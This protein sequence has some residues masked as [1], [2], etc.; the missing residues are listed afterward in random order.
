MPPAVQRHALPAAGFLA[1][2][3]RHI[4]AARLRAAGAEPAALARCTV[5]LPS[6]AAAG[7]FAAAWRAASASPAVI[8]PRLTTLQAWASGVPLGRG[9][10][11]A[12]SREAQLYEALAHRRWFGQADRWAVAAE[13][14]ALFDALTRARVRLPASLQ[15]FTQYI[16]AAYGAGAGTQVARLGEPLS[17][18]AR[19]VHDLWRAYGEAGEAGGPLDPETAYALRLSIL[20]EHAGEPLYVLGADEGRLSPAEAD[21]LERYAL[22]AEVTLFSVDTAAGDPL[23]RA[24]R[25]AWPAA[26]DEHLPA[27]ALRLRETVK[28]SPLAGRVR[29]AALPG[30]EAEARAIDFQVRAWLQA[31]H[32]SIAVVV[33]DRVVARRARALLERAQVLVEDE[34]GWALSTTSAATAVGRL[35]DVVTGDGYHRE[36]LDLMKSPFVFQDVPRAARRTAV[37]RFE[38]LL[39][40]AGPAGGVNDLLAL[41]GRD[42]D[43][44][45]RAMLERVASACRAFSRKRD[46]LA[47]WLA[48]LRAALSA[49]GIDRGFAGDA[50]GAQVLETLDALAS[51]LQGETLA[52]SLT[53]WRRWLMRRVESATFRDRAIASPVT[54][55][56]LAGTRLRRYDA[57][58]IAGADAAHLPG[59]APHARFF[60]QGVRR[61]LGLPLHEQTLREMRADLASLIAGAGETLI[62]WRGAAE[63]EP[64]LLSP[65]IE[66]LNTLHECAWGTRLEDAALDR[67][68]RASQVEAERR[69]PSLPLPALSAR[70]APGAPLP[71]L[72]AALT[73]SAY[74]DLVDCP[75]RFHVRHMLGLKE[76]DEVSEALEK[77]DY[78]SHV[79][80]VLHE[81]HLAHPVVSALAPEAA[82]Q[83]LERI[84]ERVFRDALGANY[85]D[86]AWLARWKKLIPAYIE[87]QS[88][89]EDGGWRY[90]QGELQRE[91]TLATPG[92]RSIV[93]R[94]RLD[95]VD[96]HAG[97]GG[98]DDAYALVDY[99]TRAP[100][101]LKR[102]LAAPGEDVQL[103]V[104]ALLWGA[105]VEE[106]FY[107]SL[108]GDDI[109]AVPASPEADAVAQR[110]VRLLDDLHAGAALPAHGD[111]AVCAH[112]E[113]YGLCRRPYWK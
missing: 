59:P 101:R 25:A 22:R 47:G 12:A 88:A 15:D 30:L 95:R 113:A 29:I 43:A 77:S 41:A 62:T 78:G 45:T 37:A 18:E 111:E 3:A 85:L 55:V 57:V 94:G 83:A 23:D 106:A 107:L 7:D 79:H 17:F 99:K 50:A 68:A 28:E 103:A 110:L 26:A 39:R 93:L 6:P 13:L 97:R 112:C 24:L 67:R 46:S 52:V 5:L 82:A 16:A 61:E 48:S 92:G 10:L 49:L 31:G 42:G 102:A 100:D 71:L 89:R 105:P 56:P 11:S 91:L 69:P 66:A 58:I 80:Q 33:L 8:L 81:F 75:Y 109:D 96:V 20:A 34:A 74:Q 32:R 63:G 76:A 90:A 21:F 1:G 98:H 51:E 38:Q 65:W 108:D 104:Y 40:R 53:E 70:P 2:C 86:R 73:A 44:E 64:N 84:S 72:P 35:L 4:H 27:R 19:V 60:N 36:L 87:W 14:G 54:Y 9:V